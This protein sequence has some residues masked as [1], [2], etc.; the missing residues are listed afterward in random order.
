MFGAGVALRG[1]VPGGSNVAACLRRRQHVSQGSLGQ[2]YQRG[3]V[4]L[5]HF[6]LARL[7]PGLPNLLVAVLLLRADLDLGGIGRGLVEALP[8]DLSDVPQ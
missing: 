3:R 5:L 7:P 6:S 1:H 2:H 8:H 4:V